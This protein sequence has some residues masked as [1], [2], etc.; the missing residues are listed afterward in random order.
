MAAHVH[1][2]SLEEILLHRTSEN[3][4]LLRKADRAARVVLGR[5]IQAGE[6]FRVVE[7]G[8]Y[9]VLFPNLAP[10]AGMD[11][12]TELKAKLRK[13]L[14]QFDLNAQKGS[15]QVAGPV[16]SDKPQV[17]ALARPA[18][19]SAP[20]PQ[21]QQWTTPLLEFHPVW[22][23]QTNMITG[24]RCILSPASS[25]HMDVTHRDLEAYSQAMRA[26]HALL[27]RGVKAL[28][29]VPLHFITISHPRFINAFVA[30]GGTVTEDARQL[31]VFEIVGLPTGFSRIPLRDPIAHLR[32]RSR[33][34]VALTGLETGNFE[35]YR[36]LNFHSGGFDLSETPLPEESLLPVF[37]KFVSTAQTH[38][39][40][41]FVHG[42]GAPRWAVA[43]ISAGFTYIDGPAI[44]GPTEMPSRIQEFAVEYLYGAPKGA[45][46]G[47]S[48]SVGPSG[49]QTH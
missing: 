31:V 40:H 38:R 49:G 12:A 10:K 36:Q 32:G 8:M 23:I 17:T 15:V 19:L 27:Q 35:V 2:I 37:E 34:L 24:Y 26:V 16:Q 30:I 42:I 1:R 43:A 25:A 28:L 22:N 44:S 46:A 29:I 18:T 9:H 14:R 45:L 7:P 11:R 3:A 33:A 6:I 48:G 5:E 20:N 39:L 47:R 4:T 13:E 21:L 41:A